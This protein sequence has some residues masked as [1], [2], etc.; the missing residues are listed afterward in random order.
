VASATARIAEL[1]EGMDT[2]SDENSDLKNAPWPEWANRM[3]DTIREE[4]GY[5][6]HDDVSDGVDLP[7]ELDDMISE[8]RGQTSKAERDRDAALAR[9]AQLEAALKPFAEEA[10]RYEPFE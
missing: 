3:K 2:L 1:E 6:G 9:V 10:F 5:D 8:L 4:S 7:A